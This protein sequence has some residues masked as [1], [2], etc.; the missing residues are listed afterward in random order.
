MGQR[1][2]CKHISVLT[3]ILNPKWRQEVKHFFLKVAMLHIKLK[4]MEHR[5]PCK[6]TYPPPLGLGPK[7]KTFF[8]KISHVAFQITRK[9]SIEHHANT[10]FA[11]TNTLCPWLESKRPKNFSE[12]SHA[13][14]QIKELELNA[15]YNYI[16]LS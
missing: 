16:F 1:A 15:P 7:V 13:A 3:H 14:S 8:S 6:H 4:R 2:L 10:Y 12:S 9:W 5:T 11:H